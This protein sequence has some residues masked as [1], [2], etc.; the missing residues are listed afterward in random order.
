MIGVSGK[1]Q[2]VGL[3]LLADYL[4]FSAVCGSVVGYT[5]KGECSSY[6]QSPLAA[7]SFLSF[8]ARA[9]LRVIESAT[10]DGKATPKAHAM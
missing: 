9:N 2:P 4:L 8:F 3:N 1:R 7:N 5:G 10:N 6:G